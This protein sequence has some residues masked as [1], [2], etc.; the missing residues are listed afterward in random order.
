MQHCPHRLVAAFKSALVS[1]TRERAG[2]VATPQQPVMIRVT[3]FHG[4]KY[5]DAILGSKD[6][7]VWEDSP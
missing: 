5:V 2:G 1:T 3:C 4:V 7:M 6:E